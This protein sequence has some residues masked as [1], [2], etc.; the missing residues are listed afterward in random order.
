[1]TSWMQMF[2]SLG[3]AGSVTDA[4]AAAVL[5]PDVPWQVSKSQQAQAAG[6]PKTGLGAVWEPNWWGGKAGCGATITTFGQGKA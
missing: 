2:L 3:Q 5:S 6:V 4:Q 1:M